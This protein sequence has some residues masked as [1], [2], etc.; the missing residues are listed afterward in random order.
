MHRNLFEDN[1]RRRPRPRLLSNLFSLLVLQHCV[2]FLSPKYQ[3]QILAGET[4][5]PCTTSPCQQQCGWCTFKWIFML[6]I[7]NIKQIIYFSS[8][9][10][11]GNN[12]DEGMF[13]NYK[14]ARRKLCRDVSAVCRDV[15]A[16]CLT[17]C[18][19]CPGVPGAP[20]WHFFDLPLLPLSP[21][22]TKT[23]KCTQGKYIYFKYNTSK[24][25]TTRKNVHSSTPHHSLLNN[26]KDRPIRHIL[27]ISSLEVSS[28]SLSTL[29]VQ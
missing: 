27:G 2:L 5:G 14:C 9:K 1:N 15:S 4:H 10:V 6:F 22:L 18:P 24:S 11:T 13:L 17:F 21:C 16:V 25:S 12:I 20:L 7:M 19:L 8:V 28:H 3:T 26:M 29:R 23:C